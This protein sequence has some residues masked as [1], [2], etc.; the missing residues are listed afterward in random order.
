YLPLNAPP[1]R[2][3]P[4][5]RPVFLAGEGGIMIRKLLTLAAF[6]LFGFSAVPALAQGPI[7]MSSTGYPDSIAIN[8]TISDVGLKPECAWL[9]V[10]RESTSEVIATIPRHV[11]SYAA[12]VVDR[13]VQPNRLYCYRVGLYAQPS[14]FPFPFAWPFCPGGAWPDM[15]SAFDCFY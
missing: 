14:P 10:Y 1:S 2:S 3:G 7:F 15:C 11:G 4:R 8:L 12:H 6:C 9:G 5:S 13:Y